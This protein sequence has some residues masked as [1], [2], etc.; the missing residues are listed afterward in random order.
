MLQ[1]DTF[2]DMVESSDVAIV[3]SNLDLENDSSSGKF[4]DFD[5]PL[6]LLLCSILRWDYC[7]IITR[8]TMKIGRLMVLAFL[9]LCSQ[10]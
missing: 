1:G 2:Y 10:E 6:K 5:I 7:L 3:K 8:I 9:E 4:K